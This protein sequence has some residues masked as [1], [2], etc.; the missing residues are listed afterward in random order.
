MRE[1]QIE[2]VV[3]AEGADDVEGTSGRG[4]EGP[5]EIQARYHRYF[6]VPV[7]K[8]GGGLKLDPSDNIDSRE[9]RTM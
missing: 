7:S 2:V 3:E 8:M 6:H 9:S 1:D 4:E 5:G